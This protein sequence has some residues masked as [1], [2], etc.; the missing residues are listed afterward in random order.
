ML[1]VQK[2]KKTQTN[3]TIDSKVFFMV[4]QFF[5]LQATKHLHIS[6]NNYI[7]ENLCS[8][9]DWKKVTPGD[10]EFYMASVDTMFSINS[11]EELSIKSHSHKF[12][13]F[14]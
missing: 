9:E 7:K 11:Q 10:N 2:K 14:F 3:K 1:V 12:S 4:L 6:Y 13:W 8:T 5:L